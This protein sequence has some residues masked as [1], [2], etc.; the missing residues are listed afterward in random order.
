MMAK[1]RCIYDNFLS[2][3]LIRIAGRVSTF[4]QVRVRLWL[5]VPRIQ[6]ALSVCECVVQSDDTVADRCLSPQMGWCSRRIEA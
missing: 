5:V 6:C 4:Q 3:Y 1:I 2:L